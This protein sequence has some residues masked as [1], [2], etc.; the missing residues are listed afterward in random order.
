MTFSKIVGTGRY[1]PELVVSNDDL[2]KMMDTSDEWIY[3]RTG[4]RNRRIAKDE[5]T[6]EMAAK[7]V[8]EALDAAGLDK[9]D[10]D[11]LIVAT[12]STEYQTPSAACLVQRELDINN[13]IM[14]FDVNAACTGFVY[15][16]DVA[17]QFIK[18]GKYRNAVVVGVEKLS[19]V[20]DWSD[21][22]TAVL[23][24]DGAGAVVM[25]ASEEAGII[26]SV[27]HAIGRD[28]ECLY[29]KTRHKDTPFYKSQ[30]EHHLVMDGQVVF[31][32]ACKKV[33]EVI[34]E[35]L[36]KNGMALEDIDLFVLHQAN[37][38]I[39]DRI[40]KKL[41][42]DIDKFYMNMNEYGNTS[43]ATIPIALDELARD[44]KL[45][46]KK[47]VLSGFGAGLTYG[48]TIIQF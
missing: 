15:A 19:Q 12:I 21:R 1:T 4:I 35:T 14:V 36:D 38:R 44:G 25:T 46:G 16:M 32:F 34:L 7:A 45:E 39:I 48:T 27:N 20:T 31:Q 5:T 17:D 43:S 37:K 41:K 47:V 10:V 29:I 23:F 30:K 24:G 22:A 3:P 18:T 11:L 28:F 33:P 6:Y 42:V 13:N 8:K 40:A 9:E 2:S 26:D